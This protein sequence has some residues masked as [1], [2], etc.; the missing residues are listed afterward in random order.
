MQFPNRTLL[1]IFVILLIA[2]TSSIYAETSLLPSR[3]PELV[4]PNLLNFNGDKKYEDV[5]VILGQPDSDV[6]SGI[7]V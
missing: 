5:E 7:Y 6:G 3:N 4:I 1:I 2:F